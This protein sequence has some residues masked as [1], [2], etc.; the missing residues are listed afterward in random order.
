MNES[1][2]LDAATFSTVYE[3]IIISQCIRLPLP[4]SCC[5]GVA[6]RAWMQRNVVYLK[7]L[8][9]R[10]QLRDQVGLKDCGAGRVGAGRAWV[11]IVR[12]HSPFFLSWQRMEVSRGK[13][14]CL[15]QFSISVVVCISLFYACKATSRFFC[16]LAVALARRFRNVRVYLAEIWRILRFRAAPKRAKYSSHTVRHRN[17][18][19]WHA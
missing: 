13:T 5:L 3:I 4:E 7:I 19:G 10:D 12:V 11:A 8:Y 1:P 2:K 14:S 15:Q 6:G 9:F 17:A 18:P 16:F